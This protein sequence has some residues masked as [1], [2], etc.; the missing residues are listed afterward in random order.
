MLCRR[1]Y[2]KNVPQDTPGLIWVHED[3]NCTSTRQHIQTLSTARE[4]PWWLHFHGDPQRNIRTATGRHSGQQTTQETFGASWVLWATQHIGTME[5]RHSLGVVQPM[6]GW[7]WYEVYWKRTSTTLIW[8]TTK[9]NLWNCGRLDRSPIL[10]DYIEMEL[11]ETPCGSC[12]AS[13]YDETMHK[14]QSRCPLETT[15][16]PYSPNPI[17]YGKDNQLL[18]PLD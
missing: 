17:K 15:A 2:E 11:Q 12:Y 4:S 10:W 9:K 16:L 6:W 7:F 5:T 8:C 13:I 1:R 14:I 18:S 3:T